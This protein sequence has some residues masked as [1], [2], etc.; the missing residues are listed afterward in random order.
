[1]MREA[2]I[3]GTRGSSSDKTHESR[4][5]MDTPVVF[6]TGEE[7]VGMSNVPGECYRVFV[8]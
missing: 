3:R 1:M 5:G 4:S 2:G 6:G 7:G 8:D